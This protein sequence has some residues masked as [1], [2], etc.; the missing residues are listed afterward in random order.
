M[1]SIEF[2]INSL[3]LVTNCGTIKFQ[4][5]NAGVISNHIYNLLYNTNSDF[6][7]INQLSQSNNKMFSANN[8]KKAK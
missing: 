8:I 1:P 6:S 4:F 2:I 7:A 5:S 3:C